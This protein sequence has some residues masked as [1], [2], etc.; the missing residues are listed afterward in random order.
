MLGDWGMG[1]GNI[2]N[3]L[4]DRIAVPQRENKVYLEGEIGN[5]HL[6]LIDLGICQPI[7]LKKVQE[8]IQMNKTRLENGRGVILDRSGMPFYSVNLRICQF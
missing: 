5:I 6:I 8:H 1:G 7:P 2:G 4:E 3:G